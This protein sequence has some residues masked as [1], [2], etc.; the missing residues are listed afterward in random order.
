M[1]H[2]HIMAGQSCP[3][4]PPVGIC[5]GVSFAASAAKIKSRLVYGFMVGRSELCVCVLLLLNVN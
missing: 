3:S 4:S 1:F 2:D 5:H